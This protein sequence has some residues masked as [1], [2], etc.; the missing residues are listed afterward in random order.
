MYWLALT[1]DGYNSYVDSLSAIES[2][3]LALERRTIDYVATGEQQPESDHYIKN[4]NSTTGNNRDEFWRSAGN[5]GSFSYKLKTNQETNLSLMV[6][7]FGFEWGDMQFDILIDD[8]KLA[9]VNTTEHIRIN[10]FQDINYK[11]PDTMV[12]GKESVRVKFKPK[13][14]SASSQIYFVRIVRNE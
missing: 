3:K 5:D 4:L 8:E 13:K 10:Q 14:G 1:P 11:I 12:E 6:R 9:S 7:Y 2:K